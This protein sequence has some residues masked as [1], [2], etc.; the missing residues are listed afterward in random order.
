MNIIDILIIR[1][2]ILAIILGI[3]AINTNLLFYQILKLYIN[4]L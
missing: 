4:F 2:N 3:L 1:I